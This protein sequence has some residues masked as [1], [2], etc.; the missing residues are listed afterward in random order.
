MYTVS[1]DMQVAYSV[2]TTHILE[3]WLCGFSGIFNTFLAKAYELLLLIS[4]LQPNVCATVHIS[5]TINHDLHM[6]CIQGFYT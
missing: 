1:K 3:A 2:H 5:M 4:N 6:C